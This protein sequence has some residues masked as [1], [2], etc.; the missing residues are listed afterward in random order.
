MQRRVQLC[1]D[2]QGGHFQHL[3]WQPHFIQVWH[4]NVLCFCSFC[5]STFFRGYLRVGRTVLIWRIGSW[6]LR[7]C[8][9]NI[10]TFTA[11]SEW[12]FISETIL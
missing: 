9:C 6:N 5:K 1:I 8:K 4:A 2:A 10:V 11:R 12:T 7:G 3:L